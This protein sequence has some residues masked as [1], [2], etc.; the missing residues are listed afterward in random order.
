MPKPNSQRRF[1]PLLL[2]C[3]L[4]GCANVLQP[5]P[6]LGYVQA[7]LDGYVLQ[8]NPIVLAGLDMIIRDYNLMPVW[9]SA[10]GTRAPD[11]GRLLGVGADWFA[12]DFDYPD[13]DGPRGALLTDGLNG[14]AE[15]KFPFVRAFVGDEPLIWCDDDL[16]PRLE[17][18]G[19]ERDAKIPTLLIRPNPRIGIAMLHLE[20]ML[21]FIERVRQ[22]RQDRDPSSS[23]PTAA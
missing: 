22:W 17:C 1:E 20:Q 4:D 19:Q 23:S 3:D 16:T 5:S 13:Q 14:V 10:W 11:A 12:L 18:W 15:Y 2:L 9:A 8:G 21:H 7:E 6:V